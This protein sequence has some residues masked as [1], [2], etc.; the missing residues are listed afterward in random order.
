M[1][2]NPSPASAC[3]LPVA[4]LPS[5][6]GAGSFPMSF[7]PFVA[8][9]D[10]YPVPG[11]PDMFPGRRGGTDIDDFGGPFPDDCPYGAG[12]NANTGYQGQAKDDLLV[13]C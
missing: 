12:C 13:R 9:A 1:P 11:D 6:G 4:V 5:G 8:A 7:A 3:F 10:P 2:G